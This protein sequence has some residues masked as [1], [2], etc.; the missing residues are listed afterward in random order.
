MLPEYR[1]Y[2]VP[3]FKRECLFH[4]LNSRAVVRKYISDIGLE[5]NNKNIIVCHM[6]GGITISMHQNGRVIDSTHGLD[7]DGPITPERS[8]TC[9]ALPLIKMCFSG[10]YTEKEIYKKIVG[11]GGAAAYFGTTDMRI[12]EAKAKEGV[13][14]YKLFMEAF[15]LNIAKYIAAL[16]VDVYGKVDALLFTGGIAYSKYITDAI[17]KRVGHLF[18]D[19]RIYPGENEI[20]SL[21]ENGYI[22]LSG[23]K[24]GTYNKNKL[25]ED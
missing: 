11:G 21:V 13:P 18:P 25:V 22:V 7:G 3:E 1:L 10:K 9:P 15:V 2:G 8:G 6:G 23:G 24:V 12:V 17:I 16:S 14:E 20:R 5:Q 4:A 19:I